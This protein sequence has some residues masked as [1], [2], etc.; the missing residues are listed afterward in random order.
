MSLAHPAKIQNRTGDMSEKLQ[1]VSISV[2]PATDTPKRLTEYGKKY[3]ADFTRWTFLTGPLEAL[4]KIIVN[5]FMNA[6][7]EGQKSDSEAPDLFEI[8][9]G[10]NFVVLDKQGKIRAFRQVKTDRDID[11]ILKIVRQLTMEV[12]EVRKTAE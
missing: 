11:G 8:T 5:G 12:G 9:H 7:G 4:R 3:G 2:D 6:M 10:E 1:L